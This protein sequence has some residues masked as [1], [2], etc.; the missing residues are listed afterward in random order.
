[1]GKEVNLINRRFGRL[2]VIEYLG[3]R[4]RK[5]GRNNKYWKCVCDCG[6][7]VEHTSGNLLSGKTISCGCYRK[8]K[9]H[10]LYY[11]G[12]KSKLYD[13]WRMM[14]KRCYEK[15]NP[16][17]HN[18]GGRGITVC[19]EWLGKDGYVN[20]KKWSESSGYKE[21][22]TL[23]RND[24]NKGYSPDNCSWQTMEYQ[25]N[26]KRNNRRLEMNGEVKTLAMWCKQYGADYSRTRYRINHGYSLYEALTTPPNELEKRRTNYGDR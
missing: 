4:K 7:I 5:D 10:D 11:K 16:H 24:N 21:G 25:S 1:M 3:L 12:G 18:Y 6:A 15:D 17:F 22:L 2:L 23:D 19:D 14:K 20:F 9:L 8:E 26:N 13:I